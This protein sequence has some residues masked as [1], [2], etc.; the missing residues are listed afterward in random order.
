MGLLS[1][2]LGNVVSDAIGKAK[3]QMQEHNVDMEQI[4][5]AFSAAK[6]AENQQ[7]QRQ[8]QN[9]PQQQDYQQDGK[10]K[11]VFVGTEGHTKEHFRKILNSEFSPKY[12][13]REDVPVSEIGGK[14]R[15]YDFA[16]YENGVLK[17]VVV[18]VKRYIATFNGFD[19][20]HNDSKLC[21][22]KANIP[23]INFLLHKQNKRDYVI[24]RINRLIL[25]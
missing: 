10:W 6:G 4:K 21:A 11:D 17:G 20:A 16:L 12:T 7:P 13:I 22:E 14:G 15:N 9:Q 1:K 19:N 8:P 2:I 18:T 5:K 25:K 23:F 24:D 3:E